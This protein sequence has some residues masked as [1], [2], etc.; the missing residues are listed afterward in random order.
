MER[1]FV[2]CDIFQL[3]LAQRRAP[4][5]AAQLTL[6]ERKLADRILLLKQYGAAAERDRSDLLELRVQ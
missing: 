6:V 5:L 2:A 4:T 3:D 1:L